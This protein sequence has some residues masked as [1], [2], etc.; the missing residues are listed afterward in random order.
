MW[1]SPAVTG[2][3]WQA[4]ELTEAAYLNWSLQQRRERL[5]E[6]VRFLDEQAPEL[7]AKANAIQGQVQA[8]RLQHRL[9]QPETEAM[10][11][12]GQVEELRSELISQQSELG[13]LERCAARCRRAIWSPAV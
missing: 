12:R 2:R 11:T 9:L 13:R 5:Q 1:S 10:A 4:L 8:F 3:C 6:A 7:Q